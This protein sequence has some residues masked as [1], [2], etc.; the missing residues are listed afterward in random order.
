MAETGRLADAFPR[1]PSP[2][3][4]PEPSEYEIAW[5]KDVYDQHI[6][7]RVNHHLCIA[8]V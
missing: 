7:S 5:A 1:R 3:P 4:A 8:E 2:H 6:P